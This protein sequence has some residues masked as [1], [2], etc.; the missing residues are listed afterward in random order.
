[1][2]DE[3]AATTRKRA[4]LRCGVT[5]LSAVDSHVSGMPQYGSRD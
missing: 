1:M 4:C 5:E 2:Q 3:K